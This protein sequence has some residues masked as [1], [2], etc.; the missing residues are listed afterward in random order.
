M[1]LKCIGYE[2]D[3]CLVIH[4]P[5]LN[6]LYKFMNAGLAKS[7]QWAKESGLEIS[8]SK[9][10]AMV[11]TNKDKSSYQLPAEGLKIDGRAIELSE[12]AKYLGVTLDN[13][14]K[15]DHHINEK[16]KRAKNLLFMLRG[17]VGSFW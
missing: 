7:N 3:G 13:K 4:G 5:N 14:L 8:H 16:T 15:W 12:K 6:I 9:T 10:V 2:D 1:R 17:I 11:F